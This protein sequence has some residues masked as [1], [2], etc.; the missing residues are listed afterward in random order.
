MKKNKLF[1]LCFDKQQEWADEATDWGDNDPFC[2]VIFLDEGTLKDMIEYPGDYEIG[3]QMQKFDPMLTLDRV[4]EINE[5]AKL[6]ERERKLLEEVVLQSQ[7]EDCFEGQNFV[8][9]QI[10]CD[11]GDIIAVYTG[12]SEGPSTKLEFFGLYENKENFIK[13]LQSDLEPQQRIHLI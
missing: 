12:F 7:S 8:A 10:K 11:D 13:S 6:T 9:R 4:N 3:H 1:G 2:Y 5:G